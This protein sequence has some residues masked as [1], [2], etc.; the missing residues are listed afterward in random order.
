MTD[1]INEPLTF[2]Q[3]G[4]ADQCDHEFEGWREFEDGLGS[5]AVCRK[6]GVGAME[7]SLWHDER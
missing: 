7:W 4:G 3:C 5:E 1:T 2:I 6:C